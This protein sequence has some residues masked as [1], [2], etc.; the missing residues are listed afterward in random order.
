MAAIG[1]RHLGSGRGYGRRD[2][3]M[4]RYFRRDLNSPAS[5]LS[6]NSLYLRSATDAI[7]GLPNACHL[8]AA[9]SRR[10]SMPMGE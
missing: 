1:P 9:E 10:E 4:I 7:P 3:L 2:T 5:F 8:L 6:G